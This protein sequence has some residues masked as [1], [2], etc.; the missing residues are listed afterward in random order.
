MEMKSTSDEPSP[1]KYF[2]RERTRYT[3]RTV[4]AA[5]AMEGLT[6]GSKKVAWSDS[7]QQL[8]YKTKQ[9]KI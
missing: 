2:D 4:L 9:M 5:N 8:M 7:V 1:F 3:L 6:I